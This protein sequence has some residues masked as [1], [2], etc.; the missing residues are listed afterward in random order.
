M[1]VEGS[2]ERVLG[3]VLPHEVAHTVLAHAVR[4]PVPRWA[5]E[6]AAVLAE[7][8]SQHSRHDRAARAALNAGRNVPLH[9]LFSSAEYP[10]QREEILTFYA[11]GYSVARFLVETR[12]RTTFLKFVDQGLRDGWDRAAR[13]SYSYQDVPAL[14]K[15]W[16]AW[17]RKTATPT[18]AGTVAGR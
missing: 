9:R 13:A 11:Q 14:E 2:L 16:L 17:M 6:G 7:D 18:Q 10:A 5:D 1:E 15:A 3:C 8:H 4:R 12:G